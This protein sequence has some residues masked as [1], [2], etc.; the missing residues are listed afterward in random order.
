MDGHVLPYRAEQNE[1]RSICT[2]CEDYYEIDENKIVQPVAQVPSSY[3]QD[4]QSH[5]FSQ[6]S[7]ASQQTITSNK[8]NKFS[9]ENL[10]SLNLFGDEEYAAFM[11]SLTRAEE[12]VISPIIVNIHIV[13]SRATQVPFSK[14]G[15][16]SFP[17][18]TQLQTDQLP[19]YNFKQLP[20]IVIQSRHNSKGE[21]VEAQI[22]LRKI[23]RARYY[24]SLLK[25]MPDGSMRK[26]NR[27]VDECLVMFDADSFQKLRE[28]LND[29]DDRPCLPEGLRIHDFDEEEEEM[30]QP[31]QKEM[32][33]TWFSC[34]YKFAQAIS[35]GFFLSHPSCD[36]ELFWKNLFE[37]SLSDVNRELEK[38]KLLFEHEKVT[39]YEECLASSEFITLDTLL[40]FAVEQNWLTDVDMVVKYHVYEEFVILN[41]N[42]STNEGLHQCSIG[43]VEVQNSRDPDLIVETNL[44][45]TALDPIMREQNPDDIIETNIREMELDRRTLLP[46]RA[47]PIPEFSPDYFTK[48]Y[49][50]TFM[51]GDAD[52]YQLRPCK[53][54]DHLKPPDLISHFSLMK[55]IQEKQN[56]VFQFHNTDIRNYANKAACVELKNVDV[57]T[58]SIPTEE[59]LKSKS[60]DDLAFTLMQYAPMIP[61][62]DAYWSHQKNIELE[63]KRDLEYMDEVTRGDVKY[64]TLV[65][66][67]RTQSPSHNQVYYIQKLCSSNDE[68]LRNPFKRKANA[69]KY[70]TTVVVVLSLLTELDIK[71]LA[72]AR[73]PFQ[74]YFARNEHGKN[75]NPHWHS[76]LYSQE[77]GKCCVEQQEII[78]TFF[79]HEVERLQNENNGCL[80][81]NAQQLLQSSIKPVFRNAQRC[82]IEFYGSAYTNWNPAYN[83]AGVPTDRYST[84][85]DIS[86]ISLASMIDSALST[87]D[88]SAVDKLFCEL[89]QS[90]LRHIQHRGVNGS[91]SP[92]DYCY[93]ERTVVDEKATEAAGGKTIRKKVAHCQRRKPQ[94]KRADAEIY[95][96]PH[97]ETYSQLSF[98]CNDEWFNGADSFCILNSLGN[99]DTKAMVPSQ[100]QKCPKVEICPDGPKLHFYIAEVD[101]VEYVIKYTCKGPVPIKTNKEILT[102]VT[103]KLDSTQHFTE[104]H[105]RSMYCQ[106]AIQE[107]V[108]LYSAQHSNL[109]LPLF[110][111]NT[112]STSVN[113]LGKKKLRKSRPDENPADNPLFKTTNIEVF[114]RRNEDKKGIVEKLK[115]RLTLKQFYDWCNAYI[116]TSGKLVIS[117]RK[118]LTKK[119]Y[120]AICMVPKF[121]K[122]WANPKHKLYWMH[123]RQMC[124]RSYPWE[125]ISMEVPKFNP[126]QDED[127]KKFWIDL[128]KL[129]FPQG[130][131]LESFAYGW[132]VKYQRPDIVFNE[133]EDHALPLLYKEVT[134]ATSV[135]TGKED[136]D[137]QKKT[138]SDKYARKVSNPFYQTNDDLLC[139]PH[140]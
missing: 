27:L 11:R 59:E 62:S 102:L 85:P 41:Q 45:N 69:L 2:L 71:Y 122:A 61:N 96:D 75:G 74:Y 84:S 13:R 116:N 76:L 72:K 107:T 17:L 118:R 40:K 131:G 110:L 37:Y 43:G 23:L 126:E 93:R 24:M 53:L 26:Q 135:A 81:D 39:E 94:P 115:K 29:I 105:V 22:D 68:D 3:S 137:K 124:L 48:A 34:D 66:L 99:C 64:P 138:P 109:G 1:I 103:G 121:V 56:L 119:Y 79:E 130:K 95:V 42:F 127:M 133:D 140:P 129:G 16:I 21:C 83:H 33:R 86:T 38:S 55:S 8:I 4:S 97:D 31:L 101:A 77:L 80:P 111:R 19:W 28:E 82:L 51:T 47:N 73:Y 123:C 67:F 106:T 54:D 20:F 136:S 7:N 87:S 120:H 98:P 32:L 100:L 35:S 30:C 49:P 108:C 92:K 46:D 78:K 132:F 5:E 134:S 14:Y 52:L 89:I 91:P 57:S 125:N 112:R 36:F 25:E 9:R 44:R 15:S 90:S 70:P 18:K 139:Q 113:Y 114:D 88:F 6:E 60:V 117:R 12:M 128:Y 63:T 65:S 50:A 58:L 10:F 104:K